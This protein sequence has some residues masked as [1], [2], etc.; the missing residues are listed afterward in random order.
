M[1]ELG[2]NQAQRARRSIYQRSRTTKAL[3]GPTF[4]AAESDFVRSGEENRNAVEV[5]TDSGDTDKRLSPLVFHYQADPKGLLC[6]PQK[7]VTS[8]ETLFCN[9]IVSP[10]FNNSQLYH[11]KKLVVRDPLGYTF[12]IHWIIEGSW[13]G[14]WLQ[15]PK[16][17]NTE[18]ALKHY[19]QLKIEPQ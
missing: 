8:F 16:Q 3:R 13:E 11:P 2:L 19:F 6:V 14:Q 9:K 5:L 10:T 7:K 18:N 1:S 17:Q 4:P 12:V 15:L